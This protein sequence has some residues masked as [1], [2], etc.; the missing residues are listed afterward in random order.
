MSAHTPGP[1]VAYRLDTEGHDAFA[2][3][4]RRAIAV[5]GTRDYFIVVGQ[6]PDGAADI[7]H[8]GNGPASAANAALCAAAPDLLE[9]LRNQMTQCPCEDVQECGLCLASYNAIAKA[10]G[11][12]ALGP[13]EGRQ[14]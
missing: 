8:T 11:R 9:A 10:E 12:D 3:Y 13:K 1:W 2:D 4:A 5:G 7:C 14:P 6:K